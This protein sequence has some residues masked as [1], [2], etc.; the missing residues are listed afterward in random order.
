MNLSR[1][2]KVDLK[3]VW[4]HEA[5]NFT[6]W[7]A[8]EENLEELGNTVS[9]D[10]ALHSQETPIG[11]FKADILCK[12]STTQGWV[13]IENQLHKTNHSHLG[14]LLTYAA[15]LDHAEGLETTTIIWIA[16]EFT[17]DHRAALD[18]LN[19]ITEERIRFFGLEIELWQIGDSDPAPKFNI[20][21]QPNEWSR[22]IKEAATRPGALSNTKELQLRYWE[23]FKDF[24]SKQS[25]SLR[26][27]KADPQHWLNIATGKSGFVYSATVH[28]GEGRLGAELYISN[29]KESFS[30]LREQKDQIESEFGEKLDWQDLPEAKSA[31]I[32]LYK[33]G[34]DI[35]NENDWP[36]Q[37]RWFSD[38]LI[39]L[40]KVFRERIKAL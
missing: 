32:V 28:T 10:L 22:S 16:S 39:R 6:P 27:R 33:P 30:K 35:K 12:D 31:R 20:I 14:Q 36:N 9:M 17:S 23:A 1:L 40:D 38:A 18:W 34:V 15:G 3:T 25:R 24:F 29:S 4:P 26:P 13:V 19:E 37:F 8:R 21:C 5:Q 2:K 11:A 7:L